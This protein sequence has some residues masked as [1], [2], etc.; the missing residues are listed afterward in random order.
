M[1]TQTVYPYSVGPDAFVQP[2]APA[3]WGEGFDMNPSTGTDKWG[4]KYTLQNSPGGGEG[5]TEWVLSQPYS[6]IMGEGSPMQG[7]LSPVVSSQYNPGVKP[8]REV[9]PEG[10]YTDNIDQSILDTEVPGDAAW[11]NTLDTLGASGSRGKAYQKGYYE[12]HPNLSPSKQFS[13]Y[14]TLDG[15][16][17]PANWGRDGNVADFSRGQ[18][19]SVWGADYSVTRNFMLE[20]VAPSIDA[21]YEEVVSAMQQARDE[22]KNR[23]GKWYTENVNPLRIVQSGWEKLAAAKGV[24]PKQLFDAKTLSDA[25]QMIDKR[26]RELKKADDKPWYSEVMEAIRIPLIFA[27]VITGA[28]ALTG[29][30]NGAAAGTTAAA[31]GWAGVDAVAGVE[32]FASQM[33]LAAYESAIAT[34][35]SETVALQAASQAAEIASTVGTTGMSAADI[36][37]KAVSS[38]GPGYVETA[39]KVFKAAESFY[40]AATGDSGGGGG[41]AGDTAQESSTQ[42]DENTN[43]SVLQKVFEFV[44]GDKYKPSGSKLKSFSTGGDVFSGQRGII[45]SQFANM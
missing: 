19:S 8:V 14:S 21:S 10:F 45:N 15:D 22:Y 5:M 36:V 35:L 17:A 7:D 32:G 25:D 40:D 38:A 20:Q 34:G 33:S 28:S 31:G 41:A 42:P 39:R 27:S 4:R 11:I 9:L 26:Y 37:N 24:E 44:G 3:G 16:F 6:G 43:E 30:I 13:F 1:A 12:G 2:D 29:L 18:S 23:T